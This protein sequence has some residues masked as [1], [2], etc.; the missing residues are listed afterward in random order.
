ML[1]VDYC[2]L[3]LNVV[4]IRC[5]LNLHPRKGPYIEKKKFEQSILCKNGPIRVL[6]FL[7]LFLKNKDKCVHI[8]EMSRMNNMAW[9]IYSSS[10]S[11]HSVSGFC[12]YAQKMIYWLNAMIIINLIIRKKNKQKGQNIILYLLPKTIW[13]ILYTWAVFTYLP[14]ESLKDLLI[15]LSISIGIWV[16][17]STT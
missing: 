13:L 1:H 14:S 10:H 11:L 2:C 7:G 9:H 4:E 15:I 16:S 5:I 17:S 6:H 3:G 8:L 12:L